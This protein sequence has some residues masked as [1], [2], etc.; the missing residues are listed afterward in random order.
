MFIGGA[1][2]FEVQFHPLSK[3]PAAR[4]TLTVDFATAFFAF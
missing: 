3:A 2:R 4:S 1:R